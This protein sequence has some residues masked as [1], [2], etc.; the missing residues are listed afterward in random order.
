MKRIIFFTVFGIGLLMA[1]SCK[2]TPAKVIKTAPITFKKEGTLTI[3]K[4]ETDTVLVSL[5][6]EIAESAYEKET[7][8]MYRAG[9]EIKQG[10]LFILDV[11]RHYFHMKNTEFPL[12][13]IF[14]KDDLTIGSFQKNTKPFDETSLPSNIPVKYAL[15][16]NA[17]LSEKWALKVGDKI[18]FDKQ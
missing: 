7:G 2:E 11:R 6:I 1:G 3:F 14:I 13:I 16:V 9:M 15:E 18:E 4:A 5:D 10:M 8:L 12:D 17:G